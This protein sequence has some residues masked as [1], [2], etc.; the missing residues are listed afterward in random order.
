MPSKSG[1]LTAGYRSHVL[2]RPSSRNS[3]IPIISRIISSATS[4]IPMSARVTSMT[5]D[6]CLSSYVSLM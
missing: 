2:R 3:R 5:M 6:G 4:P 1:S